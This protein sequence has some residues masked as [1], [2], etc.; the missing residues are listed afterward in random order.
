MKLQEV[1]FPH[2]VKVLQVFRHIHVYDKTEKSFENR[3]EINQWKPMASVS[4]YIQDG[5]L[6]LP[7]EILNNPAFPN[8]TLITLEDD[9]QP[10]PAKA[11]NHAIPGGHNQC[12]QQANKIPLHIFDLRVQ[13]GMELYLHYSYFTVGIP[14]RDNF[15]ICD[16]Q[17]GKPVEIKINGKTDATLSKGSARVFKEQQYVL[18]YL[19][20]YSTAFILKPPVQ[21]YT[22]TIPVERK[23][24]DL[25]K[26]L[27]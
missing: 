24:V 27:W 12:F 17:P 7:E 26:P 19:G 11:N 21:T 2:P 10:L 14:E 5:K 22:K 15:K 3:K 6:Y 1:S 16:L 20:E 8:C 13:T 18:E 25:I 23:T 9:N 4:G